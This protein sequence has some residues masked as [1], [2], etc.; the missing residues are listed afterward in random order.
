MFEGLIL[1]DSNKTK[2]PGKRKLALKIFDLKNKR[3]KEKTKTILG[4]VVQVDLVCT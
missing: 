3:T 4:R 2:R 1:S